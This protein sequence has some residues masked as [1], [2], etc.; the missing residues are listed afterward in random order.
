MKLRI[1]GI[2]KESVVDGPGIRYVIFNQGCIH[3]CPGCHNPE[4]HDL[5]GGYDIDTSEI[6]CDIKKSKFLDGITFS[7]GEPFMQAES[8]L[9]IAENIKILGLNLVIYT[10]Y[11]FEELL[12]KTDLFT[13]KLLRLTDIL[14][15]GKFELNKRDMS[16][17][18]KGS[19]NQRVIDVKSSLSIGTAVI[20]FE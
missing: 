16:L 13:G 4:T 12:D 11:T 18:F 3:N 14:I 8:L 1:A 20:L 6:I 5:G 7:G 15:D 9:K 2:V 19:R 17:K 10:G